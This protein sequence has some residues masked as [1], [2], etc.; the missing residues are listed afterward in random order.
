MGI[1]SGPIA[2]VQL[3][4]TVWF[5]KFCSLISHFTDITTLSSH[6]HS[7]QPVK[8]AVSMSIIVLANI[9]YMKYMVLGGYGLPS[10]ISEAM[11]LGVGMLPVECQM[12]NIP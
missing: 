11:F 3:S 7:K 5:F 6:N 1:V 10:G 12:D 4:S 9:S 8:I 2:S